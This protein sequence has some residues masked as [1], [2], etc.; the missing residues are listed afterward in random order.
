MQPSEAESSIRYLSHGRA[1]KSEAFWQQQHKSTVARGR[2]SQGGRSAQLPFDGV[3]S[4]F[5][6]QRLSGLRAEAK[7]ASITWKE[8]NPIPE[9]LAAEI[10]IVEKGKEKK[11]ANELPSIFKG[12]LWWWL[13]FFSFPEFLGTLISPSINATLRACNF[14]IK[15]SLQDELRL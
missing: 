5:S 4:C 6:L 11:K 13:L 10:F 3:I 2:P 9:G 1:W 8:T 7:S 14:V 12:L 15:S